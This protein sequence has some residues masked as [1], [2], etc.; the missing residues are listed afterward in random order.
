MF[1]DA[2]PEQLER[3]RQAQDDLLKTTGAMLAAQHKRAN[4]VKELMRLRDR[5]V[6]IERRFRAEGAHTA[7]DQ[8]VQHRAQ[9]ERDIEKLRPFTGDL[10]DE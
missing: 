9:I 4:H 10:L 3:L 8:V 1:D 2:T 6:R 5:A 7:A